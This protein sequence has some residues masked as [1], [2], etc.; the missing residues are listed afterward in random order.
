VLAAL[1]P[2]AV[3]PAAALPAE[4]CYARGGDARLPAGHLGIKRSRAQIYAVEIRLVTEGGSECRVDGAARVRKV[5][6]R[7]VLA[8][9]LRTPGAE[10]C[11]VHLET[12]PDSIIVATPGE[13]CRA[14]PPC[15]ALMALDGLGFARSSR[16]AEPSAAPCFAR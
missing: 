11:Q 7:E 16:L 6:G 9:P 8:F 1:L 2:L 4:G 15:G 3:L 14:R 13:A 5:A 10:A 12:G